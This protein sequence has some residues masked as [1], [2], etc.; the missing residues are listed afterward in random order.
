MILLESQ[1]DI[2]GIEF[3][4]FVS[5]KT[6][7]GVENVSRVSTLPLDTESYFKGKRHE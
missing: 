3:S 1:G 7:S 5:N 6:I 2:F 4:I